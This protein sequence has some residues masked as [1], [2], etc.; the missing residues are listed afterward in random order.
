MKSCPKIPL[1]CPNCNKKFECSSDMTDHLRSECQKVQITCNVCE[2][3]FLRPYFFTKHEC[4]AKIIDW[5]T[6]VS[7]YDGM[8]TQL[9]SEIGKLEGQLSETK[10]EKQNSENALKTNAG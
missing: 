5:R 3:D 4:T 8:I 7:N 2:I 10:G 9:E 1:N 6:M